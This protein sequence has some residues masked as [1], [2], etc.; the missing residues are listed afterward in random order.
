MRYK[1][2]DL[3]PRTIA[4][5][6]SDFRTFQA[7]CQAAGRVAL[8]ASADT[9]ELYVTDLIGRGLK[10][11][12]AE[13]HAMGIKHAHRE[14]GQASPCG[15]GFGELLAGARRTLCQMPAQKEAIG[16]ADLKAMVKATGGG[17]PIALRDSALLL[18][19]WATALRRS[20]LATLRL[21]HLTF[22]PKGIVVW[23]DHEKQDRQGVG[24][25]LAVP[26]G[27]HKCMCPV[28]AIQRWLEVRGDGPGPLFCRVMRGHVKLK[29]ILGNR[30][31]QIVQEAAARAGFD[32]RRYGAHSLRAGLATEG[33]ERGVN[34]V[35][36]AQQT[37]HR[38]LETLRIYL[39][40][41]DPFRGNAVLE[42]GM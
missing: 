28:R 7:W 19:G 33:L 31:A 2:A 27:K 25:K 5:Y 29:A 6:Q 32:R 11:T 35:M 40:S 30:V 38:S 13:R 42:I 15:A 39:R 26:F 34:E 41:R 14:A 37:G 16:L 8:P 3:A 22:T 10:I 12:T 23:I 36:I 20:N 9:V 21:E 17:S 4:S 1:T 24:R 18:F